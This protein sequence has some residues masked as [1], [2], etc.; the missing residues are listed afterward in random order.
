LPDNRAIATSS[1]LP[2]T[3]AIDALSLRR[4]D[5]SKQDAYQQDFDR[6]RLA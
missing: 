4:A 2:F 6:V 1:M 3:D 5:L